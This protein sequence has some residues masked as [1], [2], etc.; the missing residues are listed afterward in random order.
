[1][2]WKIN[3]DSKK[4]KNDPPMSKSPEAIPIKVVVRVRPILA[5]KGEEDQGIN[6][7]VTVDSDHQQLTTGF[8]PRVK[9][10]TFTSTFGPSTTQENFYM[11]VGAPALE[12][13]WQGINATMLA[14]GPSGSGK[15]FTT[16]GTP[17]EE[18]LIPRIAT[19]L[20]KRLESKSSESS[21]RV[22]LSLFESYCE[23][24]NDLLSPE[25]R[26]LPLAHI[27]GVGHHAKQLT[28]CP[29]ENY[30]TLQTLL[31]AALDARAL[32]SITTN[33]DS[34]QAHT[35]FQLDVTRTSVD[36]TTMK[37]AETTATLLV[38]DLGDAGGGA[39][40]RAAEANVLNSPGDSH[41]ALRSA[42]KF[43]LKSSR[44]TGAKQR[45][46]MDNVLGRSQLTQ[47][48]GNSLSG[49]TRTTLIVALPPT[50]VDKDTTDHTL[51]FAKQFGRLR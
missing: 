6:E 1:M 36:P 14:Y 38:A 48:L 4:K 7:Y 44:L 27:P 3:N 19:Q 51:A 40:E 13:V 39:S 23:N 11:A 50:D 31:D 41:A 42:V 5:S 10:Q 33:S 22:E 34:T 15:R 35:F 28:R 9:K 17:E 30:A 21:F 12:D 32:T 49:D 20:F 26:S 29:V 8:G 25:R 43:L 37:A 47:I 16:F 46:G 2:A 24:F 45:T 18:G